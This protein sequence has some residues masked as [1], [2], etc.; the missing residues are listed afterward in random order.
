[1]TFNGRASDWYSSENY[2]FTAMI[3][4]CGG[5]VEEPGKNTGAIQY[6]LS[7][8]VTGDYAVNFP[9]REFIELHEVRR[10][11]FEYGKYFEE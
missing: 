10:E 4:R 7:G 9:V 3:K 5:E 1:M 11:F 6:V 2:G 8:F